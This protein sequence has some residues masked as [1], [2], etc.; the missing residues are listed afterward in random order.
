M[1]LRFNMLLQDAGIDLSDVRLLRHQTD[2]VIGRTPYSL[3]RD[4]PDAFERYQS[5]Q[6]GTPRQRARFN[7]RYWASF[8]A[9]SPASSLFVGLY[10]VRLVG[11]VAAG[12]IDPLTRVPVGGSLEKTPSYDQYQ[13]T[14]MNAL[15]NYAGRL[16]VSWGDTSSARR[17]WIQRADNQDKEIVEL[18][19][20][21]K[22]ERFPGFT[23]LIRQLTE[24]ETMPHAWKEIL[25]AT[26]GVYLL[27]CPKTRE[28]YVGSAYGKEG[29]LGRWQ[30][31]AAN[32]HGG[33]VGLK[34]RDPSN[35][36]VSILEVAGSTAT[37]EDIVALENTWKLKL[38]SRDIGLN[39]N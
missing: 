30:A 23:K 24:I 27:A 6:S 12:T 34:A 28:H 16:S 21:F 14:R 31:Y 8:V 35:Y 38:H 15:S 4:D 33:N 9:P 17:A 18:N 22:E 37:I 20:V 11:S 1:A 32:N 7:G 39:H 13:C 25:Q 19:R 26:C 3:W 2:K 29:F 10:E 5:T 36:F